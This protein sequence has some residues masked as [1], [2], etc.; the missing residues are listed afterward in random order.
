MGGAPLVL[1]G[2]MWLIGSLFAFTE[3]DLFGGW[4]AAILGILCIGVGIFI[5][6]MS[7]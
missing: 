7:R 1:F 3:N 4:L 5:E 6:E 2:V